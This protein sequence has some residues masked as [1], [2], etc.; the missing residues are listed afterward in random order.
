MRVPAQFSI[1]FIFAVIAAVAVMMALICLEPKL[2]QFIG[3]L[4][5]SAVICGLGILGAVESTGRAR[6]FWIGAAVPVGLAAIATIFYVHRVMMYYEVNKV[7]EP[8]LVL[9]ESISLRLTM[10][11]FWAL[12]PISGLA[13][14]ALH[15][16]AGRR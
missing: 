4:S 6:A 2:P 16:L 8:E 7:I 11:W 3:L 5:S 9:H 13:C 10:I 1:R 15:W 14:T 12:S